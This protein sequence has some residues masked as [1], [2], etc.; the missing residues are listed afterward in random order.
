MNKVRFHLKRDPCRL[1]QLRED[2]VGG[3]AEIDGALVRGVGD[4]QD[5]RKVGGLPRH[6]TQMIGLE[7]IEALLPAQCFEVALR[8]VIGVASSGSGWGD[9]ELRF[10]Q[11]L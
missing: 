7:E 1:G 9:H 4:R 6:A 3:G 2:P 10:S 5:L 11:D 8:L